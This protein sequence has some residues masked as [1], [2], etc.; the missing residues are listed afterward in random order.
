MQIA[1]ITEAKTQLS[2]LIQ[3]ALAGDEVL[4]ARSGEPIIKLL[5][6]KQDT[7]PRVG[8]QWAGQ[9]HYA[10]S[11]EEMDKEIEE[12]FEASEVFPDEDV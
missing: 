5:P 1:N 7:S 12:L 11:I 8:G 6:Y 10:C 3:Q 2:K 9:V 4:I